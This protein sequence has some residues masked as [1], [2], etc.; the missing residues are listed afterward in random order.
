MEA[1]KKRERR[2]SVQTI[3]GREAGRTA[4]ARRRRSK[5]GAAPPRTSVH[6]RKKGDV[7]T[8]TDPDVTEGESH[9]MKTVA[10]RRILFVN[11][12]LRDA[13]MFKNH[14]FSTLLYYA[15]YFASRTVFCIMRVVM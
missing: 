9:M 4:I 12:I 6:A 7:L 5:G 8:A 13:K 2:A 3:G 1:R 14:H 10:S 15:Q 11:E